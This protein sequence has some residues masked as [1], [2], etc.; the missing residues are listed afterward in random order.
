MGFNLIIAGSQVRETV[1]S[2]LV[3]DGLPG[4]SR[5]SEDDGSSR[6]DRMG[7]VGIGSEY[8][9]RD[10]AGCNL[11]GRRSYSHCKKQAGKYK[12]YK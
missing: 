7:A 5:P 12:T 8:R 3:G 4:K 11:R 6:Y 9:P 1:C 2:L 10:C